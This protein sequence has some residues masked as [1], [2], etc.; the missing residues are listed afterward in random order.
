[1]KLPKI[2]FWRIVI[3]VIL[4][5]G[6]YYTIIRFTKGLG[7]VTNLSDN[8]PWGLW[9]GF[10]VV[11]GVGLAAGGFLIALTVYIFRI[12]NYKPILMPAILTGFL[13]YSL[14]AVGLIYDLGKWFDIWHPLV[15]WNHHSVMFEVAWCVMLYLSVLT[16]EFSTVVFEGLGFHRLEKLIHSF[17]IPIAILGVILSTLHQSSL[18]SLFLI[19]P[20]KLYKLW[21]S[22]L[23]PVFFFISAVSVGLAMITFEAFLS[24]RFL[25]KG[26]ELD[27]LNG[28][29]RVNVLIMVFYLLLKILDL[30]N[31]GAISAVLSTNFKSIMFDLETMIQI[32]VPVI[33]LLIPAVRTN[34]KGLFIA[35]LLVIVGFVMNRLDVAITGIENPALGTYFPA[36]GEIVISVFL[37]TIGFLAFA[38]TAKHFPVFVDE[39][40]TEEAEEEEI[41]RG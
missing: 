22:P 12:D 24:R 34:T 6:V 13:G 33:L 20:E 11:T 8:S 4:L 9:V 19:V 1:M 18:G 3:A 37:V 28:L 14:V 27:L 25:G 36:F 21:Y 10:D 38:F 7:A 17:I 29:A 5:L 23:L 40:H 39:K 2:T 15:F 30:V 35:S 31:R 41:V 32:I 26:L 16:L